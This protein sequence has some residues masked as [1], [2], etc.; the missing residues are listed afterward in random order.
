MTDV[1]SGTSSTP[2]LPPEI[3]YHIASLVGHPSTLARL[4]RAD[5]ALHS[6]TA[7]RLYNYI[8]FTHHGQIVKLYTQV[9]PKWKRAVKSLKIRLEPRTGI[10]QQGSEL[11]TVL[12]D[13]KSSTA[14]EEDTQGRMDELEHMTIAIPQSVPEALDDGQPE[15]IL[16][17]NEDLHTMFQV[18]LPALA[19]VK[20][21]VEF[22][23][24][25]P[26]GST[27]INYPWKYNGPLLDT[28][29]KMLES[30]DNL[31]YI[32]LKDLS[33]DFGE[34]MDG[35][36]PPLVELS[37][38]RNLEMIIVKS[39]KHDRYTE[40]DLHAT[41]DD[42]YESR[43][44]LEGRKSGGTFAWYSNLATVTDILVVFSD[45]DDETTEYLETASD[46]PL[47]GPWRS[48]II[49]A[50]RVEEGEPRFRNDRAW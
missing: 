37:G 34:R 20:G 19:P 45:G 44:M 50:G 31:R 27:D 1:A 29:T 24:S 42:F 8:T 23:L 22:S 16:R 28:M 33:I 49:P 10:D 5:R 36:N 26:H 2:R 15:A 11:P 38:C 47:N 6:L 39:H 14:Y 9:S 40:D 48:L 46:P 32:L 17:A 13:I 21:P 4:G 18:W 12:P 43:C 35:E 3:I 41:V 7:K 30:W 25:V